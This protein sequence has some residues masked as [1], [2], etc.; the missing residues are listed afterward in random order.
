MR[1]ATLADYKTAKKQ[2]IAFLTEKSEDGTWK[3][4]RDAADAL[5]RTDSDEEA[6]DIAEAHLLRF[7]RL[8]KTIILTH[9]LRESGDAAVKARFER[10]LTAEGRTI[11]PPVDRLAAVAP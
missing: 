6:H 10:L 1:D 8:G 9:H 7:I 4:L 11:L 3:A 5:A 2:A